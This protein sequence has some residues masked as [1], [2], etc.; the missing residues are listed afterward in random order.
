MLARGISVTGSDAKESRTLEAL[1]ALGPPATSA[2]TP[3][4]SATPTPWSISTAV[5][6]T[7]PE[8]VE[9][10]RRGLRLLP[11]SAA[12]ESVMQGRVV[13]AVAG[14]HGKTTTTSL[15]TVAPA[16]TAVPTLPSPSAATSTRPAPTPTRQR[17]AVS[18][19]RPTRATAR[20]S[21]TRRTP[22]W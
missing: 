9:A 16:S 20:S 19:P 14:T 2:T 13:V 12:L 22:R 4:T 11:R 7:N 6:E 1:R 5:R 17:R 3:P 8:V 21:S 18:W 10:T 15:L